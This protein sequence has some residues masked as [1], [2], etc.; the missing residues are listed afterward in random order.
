MV[1][2]SGG[3][4]P[5]GRRPTMKDVAAHAGVGLS[6]VSRVVSGGNGVS[7]TK[8]RLVEQAIAELGFSRND[9]AHTLRTGTT[10]TIGV[11]VRVISDPFYSSLI[12][13]VEAEAQSRDQLV[14]VA[15]GTDDP[16]EAVRVLHRLIRRR[17]DGL[18]VTPPDGADLSFL[19]REYLSG[20][21]IVLV[22]SPAPEVGADTVLVDNAAG[23]A[24]AVRHVAG[25]GH[26]RIACLAHTAGVY[27]SQERQR[28]F[29]EGMRAAGLEVEERDVLIVGDDDVTSV[30]AALQTLAARTEPPTALVTT[31]SRVS[32][33]LLAAMAKTG[34]HPV[35][36]GFDDF[37]FASLVSPPV[38]TVA[39]DPRAM[40]RAAAALLFDRIG[41]GTRPAR[42]L[43]L[44]TTLIPRDGNVPA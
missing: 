31:N 38:T 40:G 13:A 39:Q 6:T 17:L 22:D 3:A 32:R 28:G 23:M 4:A 37:S 11:V 1:D 18:I 33:A 26:R 2:E 36:A 16:S 7:R 42:T 12:S 5:V 21:P 35:F 29:R 44:R 20:T 34:F 43:E 24:A 25:Q 8:V 41:G 14:L 27:T 9:F 15:N 19:R 10:R 30:V